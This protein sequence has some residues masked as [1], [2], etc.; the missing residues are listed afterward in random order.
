MLAVP[1]TVL[2]ASESVGGEPVIPGVLFTAER[3]QIESER[4]A[5]E[6]L[7]L[8]YEAEGHVIE[9]EDDGPDDDQRGFTPGFLADMAPLA[10]AQP[11]SEPLPDAGEPEET[12]SGLSR[13]DAKRSKRA[14][15]GLPAS[16]ILLTVVIGG[17]AAGIGGGPDDVADGESALEQDMRRAA[18]ATPALAARRN[19]VV[20][21]AGGTVA[22]PDSAS[23]QRQDTATP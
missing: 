22:L 17:A 12:E 10:V 7:Y 9:V 16:A 8:A 21:S 11:V 1:L 6:E 20:D 2:H 15:W 14:S 13:K 3:E 4:R 23:R 19:G 5:L 18:V